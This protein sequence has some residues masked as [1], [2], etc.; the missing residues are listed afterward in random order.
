M[1]SLRPYLNVASRARSVRYFSQSRAAYLN[2]AGARVL[3]SCSLGIKYL[4]NVIH[5]IAE[6][7]H[8]ATRNHPQ[9]GRQYAAVRGLQ[10]SN[11]LGII[12]Y[13]L[14]LSRVEKFVNF[15]NYSYL[16]FFCRE[17]RIFYIW[18]S[19]ESHPVYTPFQIRNL[20]G[21]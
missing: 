8:C 12:R 11:I 5:L 21:P 6:W 3:I 18:L 10:T 9:R 20:D 1:L 15:E 14:F 4:R 2:M 17:L 7:G 13:N 16:C 19:K